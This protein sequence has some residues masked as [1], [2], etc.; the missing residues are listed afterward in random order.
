MFQ[1]LQPDAERQRL[2]DAKIDNDGARR[3]CQAKN[4]N[5]EEGNSGENQQVSVSRGQNNIDKP[6]EEQRVEQKHQTAQHQE[7]NAQDVARESRAQLASE[8]T[9]LWA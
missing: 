2:D 4:I 7:A 1:E 6:L 8:P 5:C 3:K 9:E